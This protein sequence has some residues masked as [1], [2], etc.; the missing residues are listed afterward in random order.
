MPEQ[1]LLLQEE[2][3]AQM[4]LS[5]LDSL[6]VAFAKEP[7][8]EMAKQIADLQIQMERFRWEREERQ[9]RIDFDDALNRC[10]VEV[11][12]V[13]PNRNRENGITWADYMQIDAAIRPI[14]TRAGFS[15]SFSESTSEI[16]GK[17]KIIATLS[18][19][20]IMRQYEQNITPAGNSKM[21]AT[22][23][24]AA[25]NSRAQR[26]LVLKIFNIAVGIAQDEDKGAG[27]E[28]ERLQELLEGI[29]DAR[30]VAEVKR[31]YQ[32]GKNEA[33]QLRDG[34]ATTKLNE[35]AWQRDKE[36]RG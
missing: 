12:T 18:R 2:R 24:D 30:T 17:I 27:M 22:D 23:S 16:A 35:A 33:S 11:G 26:Y 14:Y 25:A 32:A 1:G 9:A 15:L 13:V 31:L 10:Q 20:G 8:A 7:S 21:S 4:Q 3:P 34:D 6:L 29:K 28:P 5:P 19:S 36:L